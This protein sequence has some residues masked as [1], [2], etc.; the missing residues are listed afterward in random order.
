[1]EDE[2]PVWWL[3][4]AADMPRSRLVPVLRRV[5]LPVGINDQGDVVSSRSEF[6]RLLLEVAGAGE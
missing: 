1:V 3:V 4:K 2:L 6:R 5:G